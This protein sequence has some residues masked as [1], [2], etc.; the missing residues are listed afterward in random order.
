MKS[1]I[2]KPLLKSSTAFA[3]TAALLLSSCGNKSIDK[4]TA[5]KLIVEQNSYPKPY[6]WEIFCGD[7]QEAKRLLDLGLEQDGL[8][9]ILKSKSLVDSTPWVSFTDKGKAY[10]LPTK[11]ED[12][13]YNRQNIKLADQ[14]FGEI[15]GIVEGGKDNKAAMVEYT[16]VYKNITPF[17]KVI[18]RDLSKPEKHKAYFVRYD[19]GWK[20]DKSGELMMM[21]LQ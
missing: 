5:E 6:D 21:G 11:E 20:L 8:V 17:S 3:L 9:I 13:K 15:T 16:L 12:R 7:V 1:F 14:E 18:K 4:A 19:T 10:L 2:L